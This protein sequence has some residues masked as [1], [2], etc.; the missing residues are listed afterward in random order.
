MIKL[1]ATGLWVCV[2][3]LVAVYFSIQMATAPAASPDAKPSAKEFVKGESINVP[4]IGDTGVS[5]YFIT[6][7]SYMMDKDKAKD[8]ETPLPALTTDALFTL[9]VGNKMI[10]MSK[11]KAFN[12]EAFRDEIKKNLNGHLGGEYVDSVVI[13]QL[14]YLSKDEV[15]ANEGAPVKKNMKTVPIVPPE[16]PPGGDAVKAE[17]TH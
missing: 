5:G 12:V 14:D 16:A 11:P 2:V 13:E 15:R 9:L 6:K 3:T 4:I 17:K 7:I 10:D 8:L 1:V